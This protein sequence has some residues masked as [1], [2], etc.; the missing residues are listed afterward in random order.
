[1]KNKL[2][3]TMNNN[4]ILSSLTPKKTGNDWILFFLSFEKSAIS[5]IVEFKKVIIKT[6]EKSGTVLSHRISEGWALASIG[7]TIQAVV[8]AAAT[9]NDLKHGISLITK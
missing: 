8:T 4:K 9:K 1:M 2:T 6:K 7:T 3:K 5:I